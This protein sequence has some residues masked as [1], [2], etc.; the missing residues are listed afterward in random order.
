MF[1]RLCDSLKSSEM[2]IQAL[3]LLGHVARAQP[4]WLYT[5][6]DHPLFKDVLKLLKV[7]LLLDNKSVF[8]NN[9]LITC[10]INVLS[11][12]SYIRVSVH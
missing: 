12:I 11:I 7:N 3:T 5:L 9:K 6:P 8:I 2:K 1:C 4:T 10:I